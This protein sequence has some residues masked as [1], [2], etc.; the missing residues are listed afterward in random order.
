[1]FNERDHIHTGLYEWAGEANAPGSNMP[2]E[3][4]LDRSYGGIGVLIG[5]MAEGVD[6]ARVSAGL[7]GLPCPAD[8]ALVGTP[9][10][11]RDDRPADVPDTQAAHRVL[12]VGFLDADPLRVWDSTWAGL[13]DAFSDAGLGEIVFASPFLST[14]P[15]TDTY[16][17]QLW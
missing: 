16:T 13:G 12:V 9:L 2:I 11:L 8:V 15:G 14:V 7:D 3:L 5:E 4:A 17:D 10:P 6:A 1:M